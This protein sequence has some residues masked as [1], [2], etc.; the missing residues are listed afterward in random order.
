MKEAKIDPYTD[1][2]FIMIP[3]YMTQLPKSIVR[4]CTLLGF[5]HNSSKI[6]SSR[7]SP[8]VILF[9]HDH[10]TFSYSSER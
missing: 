1:L 2:S 3:N 10:E 8:R 9:F 4:Y 6:L 5:K 7:S